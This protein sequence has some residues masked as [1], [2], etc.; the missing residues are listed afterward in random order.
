MTVA[1]LGVVYTAFL[2]YRW[3]AFGYPPLV[4]LSKDLL[5]MTAIVLGLQILV[6]GM[7]VRSTR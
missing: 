5:A 6:G 2:L 3:L 7:L 1:A 4:E